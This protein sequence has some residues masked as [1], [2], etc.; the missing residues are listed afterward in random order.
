MTISIILDTNF[1]LYIL[2]FK[3]DLN[4]IIA[5]ENL[6]IYVSESVINELKSLK[7]LRTKEGRLAFIALKLLEEGNFKIVKS[8][9]SKVDEDLLILAKKYGFIVAT[10]DK[11]LRK[12]LKMNNIKTICLRNKKKI[13]V[14]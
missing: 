8:V 3:V 1:L 2:K 11:D 5:D 12:K 6:E 14:V 7:N 4:S 10:N 9:S 13:E